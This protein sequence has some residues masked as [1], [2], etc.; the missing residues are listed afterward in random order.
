MNA[1]DLTEFLVGAAVKDNLVDLKRMNH[2][3]ETEVTRKQG[4]VWEAVYQNWQRL[5]HYR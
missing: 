4:P 3:F 1:D 2:Y 5:F